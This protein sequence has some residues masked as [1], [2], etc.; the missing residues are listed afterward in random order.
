L[1][2]K[3]WNLVSEVVVPADADN[4]YPFT[5]RVLDRKKF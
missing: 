1:S 5:I 2:H 3:N 4:Q